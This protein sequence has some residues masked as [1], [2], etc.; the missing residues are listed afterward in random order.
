M[1]HHLEQP[2][3]PAAVQQLRAHGDA[4]R[5]DAGQLVDGHVTQGY[6]TGPTGRSRGMTTSLTTDTT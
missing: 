3:R 1:A 4:A 2:G 5:V 6:G